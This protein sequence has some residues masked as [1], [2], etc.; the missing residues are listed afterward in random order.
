[1]TK[2][3]Y[4]DVT[5]VVAGESVRGSLNTIDA[6]SPSDGEVISTLHL[7][8][9]SELDNA[10]ESAKQAFPSWKNTTIK[11]RSQIFFR[12]KTLLE[13]DVDLLTE[14]IV[15]ENGKTAPEAKAEIEKAIEVVEFACALPQIAGGEIL[16]VSRGVDWR[17]L[18]EPLGVV[19]SITPLNFSSMVPHWTIPNA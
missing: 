7:S 3:Q 18:R 9:K 15:H 4:E 1:M 13:R 12:Y 2:V 6:I 14:V 11:N 8:N 5:N 17:S 10:V 19:A 16:E